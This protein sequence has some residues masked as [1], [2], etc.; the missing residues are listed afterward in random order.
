[1]VFCPLLLAFRPEVVMKTDNIRDPLFPFEEAEDC[2]YFRRNQD[3]LLG[4][5]SDLLFHMMYVGHYICG[6][7]YHIV[8]DRLT[9]A[10]LLLTISGAGELR[11]QGNNYTL[12]RGACMFIDT[13]NR[14]EFYPLVEGW[15]FKY[16]HFWGGGTEDYLAYLGQSI[17]PV[18]TLDEG[19]LRRVEAVLDRIME[20]TEAEAISDYPALSSEIYS[21]LMLLIWYSQQTN[22]KQKPDVE[23]TILRAVAYIQQNYS[24]KIR[25]E[26]L[27][28][29]LNLSRTNLFEL[30]QKVYGIP[31]HEY[32]TQYRLSLAKNMLI[33][34]SLS[35]TEIATRT[36]FRDIYSFSR[37]FRDKCG[38]SP[39]EF[40][41]T[42]KS[43]IDNF[44]I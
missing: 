44:N 32:L 36:G 14:H 4:P 3:I 28:H 27:A 29:A 7:R 33:N 11:Y 19:E 16:L 40:R 21:L 9:S 20:E 39:L 43:T 38:M 41:N 17:G 30:F 37:R 26:D 1:M 31:P 34:T 5:L 2:L 35:I 12:R 22:E 42:S 10:L 8:R 15:E 6:I 23:Q 13:R 18:H 25:T 24:T